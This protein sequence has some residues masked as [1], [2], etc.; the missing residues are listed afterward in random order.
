MTEIEKKVLSQ[1]ALVTNKERL[2]QIVKNARDKSPTVEKAAFRR[3]VEVSAAHAPE[4]IEHACWQMVY[5]VEYLRRL[6]GRKVWRMNHLRPK[7]KKD[8][9]I[10][11]LE[12]CAMNKTAGFDEVLYY[13]L[14]ELTAEAMVLRF[15]NHFRHTTLTAA[16]TRLMQNGVRVDDQGNIL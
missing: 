1:I 9:E 4:T 5:T 2:L 11:A 6:N 3:L 7:I 14:P 15:P 12:Y 8:G 10:G 13:G 16:R